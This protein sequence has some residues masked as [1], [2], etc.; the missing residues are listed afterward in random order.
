MLF[1]ELAFAIQWDRP[2][3]LLIFYE[4][5]YVRA[6]VELALEKRLAEIEQQV[7]DLTVDEKKFDIPL[8]LSQ[9]PDRGHSVYSITGLSWGGGKENA[10]AYRALNIRRE[11]FV[12][13][14]IRV[15]FWLNRDEATEL[16]RYAPDFW[17]FRHRVVEFND[18]SDL[19]RLAIPANE[20]TE[21]EPEFSSQQ[22]ELDGQIT[23]REALLG[24]MPNTDESVE[25]RLDLLLTLATMYQAK[26]EYNQSILRLKQGLG[27]AQPL[28]R[29]ELL[30]RF[31]ERLGFVYQDLNNPR[32]A[33][34]AFRKAIR[35][36]PEDADFW[37]NLGKIYLAQGRAGAAQNAFKKAIKYSPD[38]PFAW[39]G[40]GQVYRMLGRAEGA[41]I[42][43]RK[44]S[45]L[46]PQDANAWLKLGNLYIDLGLLPE[47]WEA[48]NNAIK[49]APRNALSWITLGLVYRMGKR[50]S[51]AIIPCQQAI[52][53]DPQNPWA[54][55]TLIACYRLLEKNN[56]AEEHIKLARP[57][58]ENESE[59]NKGVFE[60]VCGNVN[61]A[62]QWL[63]IAVEKK[64]VG[65]NKLQRDPNLDFIRNDPRFQQLLQSTA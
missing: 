48:C 28:N 12:D 24:D 7:V 47:A 15:I 19:L 4:S 46:A 49:L 22:K 43:Y 60:S 56:L 18:A 50:I 63:A 1:E 59:Y 36:L 33:I 3:I 44:A 61:E 11:L 41:L 39:T 45:Q 38:D 40:L 65:L 21:Y 62:I 16:T 26:G 37:F 14:Q 27:L 34:R 10:N 9:R 64:Q 2:S 20:I 17:A 6:D 8:L 25:R 32:N 57:I 55:S 51:D 35:L 5:E 58:M 31:W 29:S 52:T 13:Y 54:Y 23:L 53:L 42:A 30:P